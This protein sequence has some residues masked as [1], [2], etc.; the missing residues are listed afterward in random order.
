[1]KIL[2]LNENYYSAN[3]YYVEFDSFSILIDPSCSPESLAPAQQVKTQYILATHGHFDHCCSAKEWLAQKVDIPYYMAK[4]DCPMAGDA[5]ANASAL[6]GLHT[7]LAEASHSYENILML[8]DA[9]KIEI[10]PTPGHS[11]GSV[12]LTLWQLEHTTWSAQ[13]I[14]T[15][16]TVFSDSVG[17]TDLWGGDAQAQRRSLKKIVEYG[18][19]KNLPNSVRVYSGH[20]PSCTWQELIEENI[21]IQS[22]L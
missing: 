6:F 19:E 11:P 9:I 12:V 2:C 16:D 15:G 18:K 10:L 1:M 8:S 5:W 21:W 3:A 4:E 17:R 20:G 14:F 13:A 22:I 7:T